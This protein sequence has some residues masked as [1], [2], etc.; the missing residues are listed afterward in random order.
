MDNT[1]MVF[2]DAKQVVQGILSS[3]KGEGGGH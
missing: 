3:L 1:L 2:G